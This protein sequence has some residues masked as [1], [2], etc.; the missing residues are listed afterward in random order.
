[1]GREALA[2]DGSQ[3]LSHSGAQ[4]IGGDSGALSLE[5]PG[6]PARSGTSG[7]RQPSDP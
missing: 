4:L 1:M 7:A 6:F 5:A 2:R 3:S